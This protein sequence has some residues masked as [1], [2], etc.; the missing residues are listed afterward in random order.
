MRSRTF[1]WASL[2][3]ACNMAGLRQDDFDSFDRFGKLGRQ[4]MEGCNSIAG[5]VTCSNM[6][7]VNLS[8][9]LRPGCLMHIYED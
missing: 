1:P 3:S 8:V 6:S 2:R 9:V 5:I 4:C 7:L